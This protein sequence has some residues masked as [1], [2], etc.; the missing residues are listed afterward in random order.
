M[1]DSLAVVS[2]PSVVGFLSS[3]WRGGRARPARP[4]LSAG[5][6][7][8]G[9][10]E[11]VGH[12]PVGTPA[13]LLVQ[14]EAHYG[15]WLPHLLADL[16][17][18]GPVFVLAPQPQALDRLLRVPALKQAHEARR[19][20]AWVLP[21]AAERQLQQDGLGG[22]MRELAQVGCTDRDSL[23]LLD[24]NAL[25]AGATIAQLERLG[26]QLRR[27]SAARPRPF[28]LL[29]PTYLCQ[30]DITGTVRSLGH[31][32]SHVA[33]LGTASGQPGLTLYRWDADHG[34]VFNARYGLQAGGAP[35]ERLRYD[36]SLTQGAVPEMVDAPDQ[37][38]VF[39][40]QACVARQRGVPSAW[41]IVESL[42]AMAAA[43][44][45]AVG[46]TVLLDAGAPGQFE[47]LASL[48]HQLR[49][50][51]PRTLKIVVRETEGKLRTHSEQA[52]L[53]LGVSAVAYRELGFSR[54]LRLLEDIRHQAYAR[55]VAQDY[56]QALAHFMP[57]PVRG[58]QP[59]ARFVELA[60]AMLERTQAVGLTH[61]L[62]R[63]QLLPRVAHLDALRVCQAARDGDLITADQDGLYVF[64]F[65]CREPDL[66]LALNHL[67]RLP[68][69]QLF[70]SQTSDGTADGIAVMLDRL[71]GAA[72]QGLPD[73][74]PLL[75]PQGPRTMPPHTPPAPPADT[76][77]A[78]LPDAASAPAAP[79][80]TPRA[81]SLRLSARPIGRRAPQA[82]TRTTP[83][84]VDA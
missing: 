21:P 47:A 75:A 40:T 41:T 44:H 20:R 74:L 70:S 32:F 42:E 36:G 33:Q 22:L 49:L 48:V 13:A 68:L 26:G 66:E 55:P 72:R 39:A 60:Q 19:L 79:P 78:A 69:S 25:L 7:I 62:A 3:W 56:E 53:R 34:A 38:A 57:D 50:T 43:T 67:F 59:P 12:V 24:A 65:A 28:A 2:K 15:A 27:W 77:Q 81:P 45:G 29:F 64:L 16:L 35:G 52:L 4:A 82:G 54:L 30:E 83:S 71:R 73:Y 14:D 9:L 1:P 18:A 23:C 63:L 10:P 46:A 17:A 8:D 51:R 6:G 5:L 11:G 76:T 84:G 37:F 61:C 80:A 31:T 58:Y